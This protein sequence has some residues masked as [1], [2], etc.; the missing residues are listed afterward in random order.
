MAQCII[1]NVSQEEID[2]LIKNKHGK[3]PR[4]YLP[5]ANITKGIITFPIDVV[6]YLRNEYRITHKA[7]CIDVVRTE[8]GSI[9]EIVD[10][11][12]FAVPKFLSHFTDKTI[13]SSWT[14][15]EEKCCV[16]YYDN[17]ETNLLT[18]WVLKDELD[19]FTK[20]KKIYK[21]D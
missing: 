5:P 8:K 21:V 2:M 14:Y 6:F 7:T 3:L 11:K 19:I 20:G 17:T 15:G 18:K 12:A 16:V 4:S 1:I 9:W 10:V 13:M